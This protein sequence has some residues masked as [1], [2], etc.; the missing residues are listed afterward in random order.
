M[1]KATVTGGTS[2]SVLPLGIKSSLMV[3]SA[4]NTR[5]VQLLHEMGGNIFAKDLRAGFTP[6]IM[7]HVQGKVQHSVN[8]SLPYLTGLGKG[9]LNDSKQSIFRKTAMQITLNSGLTDLNIQR[10]AERHR[11]YAAANLKNASSKYA[12]RVDQIAG[13]LNDGGSL[14]NQVR[15]LTNRE[16]FN[17]T[18]IYGYTPLSVAVKMESGK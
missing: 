8:I 14:S 7:Q 17:T 2:G 16:T 4:L 9:G 6:C 15:S 13:G 10:L 3:A 18:K 1:L 5:M 12:H 11:L